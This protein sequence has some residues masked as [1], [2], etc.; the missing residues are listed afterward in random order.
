M[1]VEIPTSRRLSRLIGGR[2]LMHQHPKDVH[3]FFRQAPPKSH[4]S[5]ASILGSLQMEPS[6]KGTNPI[7]STHIYCEYVF[8]YSHCIRWNEQNSSRRHIRQNA[9][10]LD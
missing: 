10:S 2:Y 3:L 4:A 1:V 6:A 8:F 9:N 5:G 7:P